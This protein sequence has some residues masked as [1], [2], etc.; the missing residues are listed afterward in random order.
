MNHKEIKAL[1]ERTDAK[2]RYAQVHLNE[3]KT[4]GPPSGDDFDKAHQ[5]SFLFH[6]LGAREAFLHE[7]NF[8]YQVELQP[9]ELSLGKIRDAAIERGTSYSE[10]TIL[11]KL[12]KDKSS[13]YSCAKDMRD[14]NTHVRGAL[15]AYYLGGKNH[16]KV[17]LKNPKTGILTDHFI[18]EFDD[19]LNEMTK[20][21]LS[22][23]KSAKS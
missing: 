17:K 21:I 9:E 10:A 1:Q 15:R 3:L 16:Q 12:G 23:R 11:Y 7:L 4:Q 13:W 18:D 2:L 5:E 8:Y 20:L 22:L 6:L 14:E 19:W